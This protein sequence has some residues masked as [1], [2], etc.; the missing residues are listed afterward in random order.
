MSWFRRF[1]R[2]RSEERE[3]ELRVVKQKFASFIELLDGN[4]HDMTHFAHQKAMEELLSEA[5]AVACRHRFGFRL[6]TTIPLEVRVI[7]MDGPPAERDVKRRVRVDDLG[8]VPLRAFWRGVEEEGWPS[9]ARQV[10]LSGFVSV[11]TTQMGTGSRED[12]VETSFALVS[13]RYMLLRLHL[14][15]HFTTFESMCTPEPSKNYIRMQFKGGGA[16]AD[17]RMRRIGLV[18]SLLSRMGFGH[19]SQGD[20][21][22]TGF[23]YADEGAIVE[24]LR[25]LGRLTMLTKQLDMALANDSV[26]DWYADDFAGKLGLESGPEDA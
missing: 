18:M 14:G 5:M 3:A 26:A 15:Y 21:L 4:K 10:N 1:L 9:H 23:S 6:R 16:S 11:V 22:D 8:S 2:D 24:R 17:R 12:F 20:S 7:D 13:N 19:E 25:L